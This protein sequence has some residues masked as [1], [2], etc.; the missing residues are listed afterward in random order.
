MKF[1]LP[2]PNKFT[3]PPCVECGAKCCRYVAIEIDRPTTKKDY[4]HIRWYLLHE[5]VNVFLDHDKIWHIEFVTKCRAL[6]DNHLCTEY[7]RRP[8]LCRDHGW[9][10]G[11]CEF[12]DSPY[13]HYFNS[14]ESFEAY[15]DKK[16][17]D[18]RFKKHNLPTAKKT[19]PAKKKKKKATS[20]PTAR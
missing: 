14:I 20:K 16:G 10:I 15:L 3:V 8:Q 12:F 6:A 9:P 1:K 17:I 4:D 19:A 13:L 5:N 18:W 11:S 7:E 2:D